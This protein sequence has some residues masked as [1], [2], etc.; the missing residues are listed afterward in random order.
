MTTRRFAPRR[1]LSAAFSACAIA[2]GAA[3]CAPDRGLAPPMAMNEMIPPGVGD[4]LSAWSDG[5]ARSSAAHCSRR[6]AISGIAL[7][8]PEGGTLVVGNNQLIVPAGALDVPTL[9]TGS[10]PADT[11]A[12]IILQPAGLTF[13]KPA[14]LILDAT[15]CE[16]TGGGATAPDVVYLDANG[17]V[18][19]YIQAIFSN[20]WHTF[21][22]PIDHFSQYAV[23]V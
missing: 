14:G 8:G 16:V 2:L 21:A 11:I 17:M 3:A 13:K 12:S 19:E 23:A 22:A 4:G 6:E 18:I 10:V 7:I 9:I 15:G 1:V 5:L 20:L